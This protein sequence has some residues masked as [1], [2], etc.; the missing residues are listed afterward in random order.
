MSTAGPGRTSDVLPPAPHLPPL[1]GIRGLSAVIIVMTHAPKLGLAPLLPDDLG[2]YA[3]MVFFALSGFLMGHLYLGRPF[4]AAGGAQYAAARVAR[5][6]PLYYLIVLASWA[7][8]TFVDSSFFYQM[9]TAALPSHL[10]FFGSVS[11]FWTIGP[12]VQ[13]YAV[14]LLLWFAADRAR[15][16]DPRALTLCLALVALDFMFQPVFPGVT[17]LS[18]LHIFLGG[19]AIAVL[20]RPLARYL[21]GSGLALALQ[22]AVVGLCFYLWLGAPAEPDVF[23]SATRDLKLNVYYGDWRRVMVALLVIFAFSFG[24]RFAMLTMANPLARALGTY[25]YSIYLL[26]GPVLW[27]LAGVGLF[28][29]TGPA[30]G[31]VLG[32][33]IVYLVGWLSYIV[34]EMPAQQALRRPLARRFEALAAP[35]GRAMS[36]WSAYL[37]K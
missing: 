23:Y 20:R 30:L 29:I 35:I 4:T 36:G 10:L 26:H 8:Y 24:T 25:S 1:D 33:A 12:E 27:A 18:K 7:I 37:A 17:I 3:V 31:F 34:I 6:V 13:F 11:Y 21:D 9:S 2:N 28:A 19:V 5:I 32:L 14:F 22:L 16:G 15:A